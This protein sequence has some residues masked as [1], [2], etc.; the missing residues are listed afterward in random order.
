[1]TPNLNGSDA[2]DVSDTEME[3]G[4]AI[5]AEGGCRLLGDD[6]I[7]AA[8]YTSKFFLDLESKALWPYS[9][10]IACRL[11]EIPNPGDYFEYLIDNESVLVVRQDDRS[12][13]AF[14]NVCR[15][16]STRLAEGCGSLA[17]GKI[18]CRYH[19]WSWAIDGTSSFVLDRDEFADEGMDPR[20]LAL[21]E[22]P[23]GQRWGF[24]FV[25][26]DE[27][28]TDLETF[29]GPVMPM[30]DPFGIETMRHD[31]FKS[32]VLPC[33]WKAALDAFVENY[34]VPATHPQLILDHNAYEYL[35]FPYG[36]AHNHTHKGREATFDENLV[37]RD[38]LNERGQ[39]YRA[40]SDLADQINA[41]Y[42]D[43][44]K[45]IAAGLRRRPLKE[46]ISA[47]VDFVNALHEYAEGAGIPL[48]KISSSD[49][50]Y[51][52][53]TSIFPNV[54]FL[55]SNGNLLGYR[56]RPN[57]D[58]PNSCHFD[59]WSLRIFVAGEEPEL[60]REELDWNDAKGWRRIL[61]QDFSNMPHVTAG[62]RSR[63]SRGY[64]LNGHQEMAI[65][66]HHREI[67]RYIARAHKPHEVSL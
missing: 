6:A 9:W 55:T 14:A 58:D 43:R 36:H 19:G 3:A 53:I 23:S 29:L 67:D 26:L 32:T 39:L 20:S 28:P 38:Q 24:V 66:N 59:V 57:G 27:P 5:L 37:A 30:L 60:E 65:M 17:G 48:P 64:K 31:W 12:I 21:I 18:A 40:V 16:R 50:K 46:G 45:F 34:H 51:L 35:Q 42:T 4:Q 25:C 8:R 49:A 7:P 47:A 54:V 63:H 52:G 13:K 2:A 15:H 56:A 1:M 33:N 44:E 11:E 22:V 61:S 41:I 10:Q 62:L